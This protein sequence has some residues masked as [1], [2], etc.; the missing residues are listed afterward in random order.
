M[1]LRSDL[2]VTTETFSF[3]CKTS[4]L[5]SNSEQWRCSIHICRIRFLRYCCTI[6]HQYVATRHVRSRSQQTL[7]LLCSEQL[8]IYCNHP[9]LFTRIL[10]SSPPFTQCATTL[11]QVTRVSWHL[12][13]TTQHNKI[14]PNACWVGSGFIYYQVLGVLFFLLLY[15]LITLLHVLFRAA[16]AMR[17]VMAKLRRY[18]SLESGGEV[19]SGEMT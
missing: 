3:K 18:H 11:C 15:L 9:K 14:T 6:R 7:A 8:I 5:V 4:L 12:F 10:K 17:K 16:C 1:I 2:K 19:R 13:K